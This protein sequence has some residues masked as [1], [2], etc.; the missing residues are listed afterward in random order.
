MNED[1]HIKNEHAASEAFTRQ[2]AL[3]DDLYSSDTITSYK[4]SRVREHVMRYLNPNSHILELNAGTGEDA[5][6]FSS[7]GHT[8]HATD[9]SEGMQNILADK[10]KKYRLEN[11]VTYER[12]S[13]T[14]LDQLTEKGPYDLILSNFAGLNCTNQ[15]FSILD[16]LPALLKPGGLVT[17]VLLPRFCLWEFMF[18]S[19]GKF[20]TAFRR[21]IP[22]VTANAQVEGISFTC[23]Y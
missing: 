17:L 8:V 1:K 12:C 13:Y 21:L 10:V 20:K 2:S 19:K 18:L 9:I 4:R 15:L 11:Q 6:F 23:W 22:P 5:L 14:E 7:K 16:Q 3:F